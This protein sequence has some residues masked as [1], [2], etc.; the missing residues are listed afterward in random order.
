MQLIGIGDIHLR[1]SDFYTVG[2]SNFLKWFKQTIPDSFKDSTEIILAGDV[3]NKI[4]MSPIV[5]SLAI[6]LFSTLHQKASTVYVILGNH[7]YGLNKYKVVNVKDFLEGLGAVVIDDLCEFQTKLGFN[8]LCLPWKYNCT[9]SQVNNFLQ[10]LDVKNKQYDVCTAHWELESLFGSDFVDLQNVNATSYMC[11]HIHSHK[12]NPKYL[13]SIL[14]NSISELKKNDASVVKILTKDQETG[15]CKNN[16]FAIPSFIDI[17]RVLITDLTDLQKLQSRLDLFYE[18]IHDDTISKKDIKNQ[19][20]LLN[21]QIYGLKRRQDVELSV[22]FNL[23]DI[24]EYKTQSHSVILEKL[25][26]DL[27][28]EPVVISACQ[29][30]I[31]ETKNE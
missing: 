1:D 18:I 20:K 9:H 24:S 17:E 4:T 27:Q 28:L 15:V 7:D 23:D 26:D 13:G 10:K 5:G 8:L 3:L 25:Q 14:P 2:F 29:R 12:S 16:E 6:Q 19:M 21:L 22:E 11:G 31:Q 30:A